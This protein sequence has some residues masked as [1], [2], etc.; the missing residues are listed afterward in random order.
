[1]RRANHKLAFKFFGPYKI[2]ERVGE[3]AY[4]LELPPSSRVHPVFHVSQLKPC[5]GPNQQV[6]PQLPSPTDLLQIPVAVLGRRVRQVGFRTVPQALIHW[7]G[8]PEDQATWE[9][10]ESLRQQFPAAPAWGQAGFQARGIVN[11]QAPPGTSNDDPGMAGPSQA[12]EGRPTR[13][14]KTPGWLASGDWVQ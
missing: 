11:D 12:K 5:I 8:M 9:D 14:K 6:L 3:V 2:V 10:V 13:K 4:K 1:V 7:S